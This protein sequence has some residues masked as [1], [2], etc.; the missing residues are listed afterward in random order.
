MAIWDR[1]LARLHERPGRPR[2]RSLRARRG[3]L[4]RPLGSP[5]SPASP[6]RPPD[7]PVVAAKLA[8]MSPSRPGDLS[9][10]EDCL[11]RLRQDAHRLCRDNRLNGFARSTRRA[12]RSPAGDERGALLLMTASAGPTGSCLRRIGSPSA[13]PW[14]GV[15]RDLCVKQEA[16][17]PL[18]LCLETSHATPPAAPCFSVRRCFG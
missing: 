10:S 14:L 13:P 2:R 17:S 6:P 3:R 12:P 5:P 9:G 18:C 16:A 4:R 8:V 7:L 15:L 11:E 1:A